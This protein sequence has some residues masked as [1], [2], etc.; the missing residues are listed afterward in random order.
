MYLVVAHMIAKHDKRAELIDTLIE[1]AASARDEVGCQTCRYV[2]DI[3]NELSFSSI[4][5][6]DDRAA[7]E[8]HLGSSELSAGLARLG[9][10]VAGSPSI[11]GYDV[12]ANG[13]TKFA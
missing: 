10:L 9:D 11:V 3:E 12:T 4:E 2:N 13:A 6:W 1:F 7:L 5:I 8:A